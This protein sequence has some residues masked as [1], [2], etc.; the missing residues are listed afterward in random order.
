MT[1]G[2]EGHAPNS[3]SREQR[4]SDAGNVAL[5]SFCRLIGVF[6][7]MAMLW[8]LVWFPMMFV[9]MMG[10]GAAKA[11]EHLLFSF[12]ALCFLEL[13][14][15]ALTPIAAIRLFRL[16][17]PWRSTGTWALVWLMW[18]MGSLLS[19][20]APFYILWVFKMTSS[21]WAAI[22]GVSGALSLVTLAL[23]LLL[24]ARSRRDTAG[25]AP[26]P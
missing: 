11:P 6:L 20:A 3:P 4:C 21:P 13:G 25:R 14:W 17:A 22:P 1:L 10:I 8:G 15:V 12:R 24:Y 26:N 23:M 2:T 19:V 5:K 9:C 16:E 18:L 7:V